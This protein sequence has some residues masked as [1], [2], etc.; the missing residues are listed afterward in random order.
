MADELKNVDV[1]VAHLSELQKNNN[2]LQDIKEQLSVIAQAN[3]VRD[4]LTKQ[5]ISATKDAVQAARQIPDALNLGILRN[6]SASG[7]SRRDLSSQ[8][9]PFFREWTAAAEKNHNLFDPVKWATR[10]PQDSKLVGG[11]KDVA[12]AFMSNNSAT[13]SAMQSGFAALGSGAGFAS[14]LGSVLA[15]SAVTLGVMA[16]YGTVK[17]I[18]TMLKENLSYKVLAENAV[19]AMSS[20]AALGKFSLQRGLV[21]GDMGAYMTYRNYMRR[22]GVRD[23]T[24]ISNAA[25][26]LARLGIGGA[27]SVDYYQGA[28]S[29][30]AVGKVLGLNI[31]DE[32]MQRLYRS[33]RGNSEY[34][35]AGSGRAFDVQRFAQG[36]VALSNFSRTVNGAQAG[37][38]ELYDIFTNMSE[39]LRGTNQDIEG[40]QQGL[41]VYS[42]LLA[43]NATTSG[44]ISELLTNANRLSSNQLF[45]MFAFGNIP[46]SNFFSS[47]YNF[48][49]RG[50]SGVGAEQNAIQQMQAALNYARVTGGGDRARQDYFIR[51]WLTKHGLG[52][53]ASDTQDVLGTARRIAYGDTEELAKFKESVNKYDTDANIAKMAQGFD[54]LE[55]PLTHIRDLLFGLVVSSPVGTAIDRIVAAGANYIN[56]SGAN[57]SGNL[58]A[59]MRKNQD[60]AAA[61]TAT[62]T[63]SELEVLNQHLDTLNNYLIRVSPIH[64]LS[65]AAGAFLG[66]KFNQYVGHQDND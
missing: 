47:A 59:D 55:K 51:E 57:L 13:Q 6:Y 20:Q 14:A 53:F 61:Q 25:L 23:D 31:G 38:K 34:F 44:A 49:Q 64:A 32:I 52:R 62:K 45:S 48:R 30:A 16:I 54:T 60:S 11:I 8:L 24:A 37:I 17:I 7:Q 9:K 2:Q 4:D 39:V 26:G 28:Y 22:I 66:N 36:F 29:R 43:E 33:T 5:T 46:G 56:K 35:T 3:A 27:D 18:G 65:N 10:T 12:S 19:T 41:Q 50:Y 63:N 21:G 58:E 15:T 42:K 40:F 1:S